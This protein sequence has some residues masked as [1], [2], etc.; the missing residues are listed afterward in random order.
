MELDSRLTEL[1]RVQ[2]W[3]DALA[4]Q[5]GFGE[6][7]R[8]AMHLCVEEALAN[9]VMHGYGNEPGHPIVMRSSVS[10]NNLLLVIEDR[11]P[12]FVPVD[13]GGRGEAT[14][15]INLEA[16]EPGGNGIRLLYR[17]AGSVA[18]ER[19]AEGNRLTIGFPLP[20]DGVSV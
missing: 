13:P 18:Y 1:T 11:A 15:A 12:A 9:V 7:K 3:I 5:Y 2:P 16:I 4:D 20:E 19:L 10:G 17:F 8:F 14:A 6:D